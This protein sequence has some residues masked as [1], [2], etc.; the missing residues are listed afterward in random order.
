MPVNLNVQAGF[1]L[2]TFLAEIIESGASLVFARSALGYG[3]DPEARA[4]E[5]AAFTVSV[6][7]PSPADVLSQNAIFL[8]EILNHLLLPLV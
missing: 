1:S 6:W 8:G 3:H 4:D 7:Q 2:D 5:A